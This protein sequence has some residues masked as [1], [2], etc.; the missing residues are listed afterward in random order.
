MKILVIEDDRKT[1]DGI[2]TILTKEGYQADIISDGLAGLESMLSG[3]YDLVLLDIALPK[4]NGLDILRNARHEGVATPVIILT[5]RSESA[6]KIG[7][8]DSSADDY[9]T[10]PFDAG[11]LLARIRARTRKPSEEDDKTLS[12]GSIRLDQSTYKLYGREK[13]IKLSNKEYQLLEYLMMNSG[14]ILSRDMLISRVWGPDS[15]AGDNNLEVYISF[16]RQKLKFVESEASIIT[17]K[18]VG[19]SIEVI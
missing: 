7:G 17:T 16:V 1:A 4:L 10:K 14:R 12:F 3:I 2:R 9:L 5:A 19:Y 6:D 13:S 18:G 8:L 15:D 11:E